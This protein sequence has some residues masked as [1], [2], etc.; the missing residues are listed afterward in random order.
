M[1]F[2]GHIFPDPPGG[3]GCGDMGCSC[4]VQGAVV[5][6]ILCVIADGCSRKRTTPAHSNQVNSTA[7]NNNTS[8]NEPTRVINSNNSANNLLTRVWPT[9]IPQQSPLPVH[10]IHRPVE[11]W[12]VAQR[13]QVVEVRS[14]DQ[15][16]LNVRT[17]PGETDFSIIGHLPWNADNVIFLGRIVNSGSDK[18]VLIRWGQIVGW[19]HSDYLSVQQ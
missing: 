14:D 2:I 15:Q 3:E 7:T 16:G 9:N 8:I 6:V 5:L 10:R 18:W 19:V 17:Q 4:L 13:Y 1:R 12:I 11:K